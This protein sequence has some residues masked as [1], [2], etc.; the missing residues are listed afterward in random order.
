MRYNVSFCVTA[1]Q[2]THSR[3]LSEIAKQISQF[4]SENVEKK[5]WTLSGEARSRDR[6]VNSLLEEDLEFENVNRVGPTGMGTE[7]REGG[8]EGLIKRRILEVSLH[9]FRRGAFENFY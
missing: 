5:D 9:V 1:N 6:P 4:E 3:R 7:E 2:S 8:L